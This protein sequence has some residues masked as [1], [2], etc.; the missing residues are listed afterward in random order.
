MGKSFL[1]HTFTDHTLDHTPQNLDHTG[2][3]LDHTWTTWG[4]H[5]TTPWTTFW[6]PKSPSL[7][8]LG[9]P[10]TLRNVRHPSLTIS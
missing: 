2:P 8:K 4:P 6:G 7:L 1:D 5:W 9:C 10:F 3:H